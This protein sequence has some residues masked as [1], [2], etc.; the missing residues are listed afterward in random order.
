MGYHCRT[1]MT[2]TFY[3]V[4]G[5]AEDATIDEIEAAYRER[6]KHVHPDVNDDAD[7]GESTRTLIEARDVL[8]DEAERARYDRLGHEAYVG[9]DDESESDVAAAARR[10]GY[11]SGGGDGDEK[12]TQSNPRD[13]RQ[14]ARER[15]ERER[16]ASERVRQD[17]E[18]RATGRRTDTGSAT[19]GDDGG[20]DTGGPNGGTDAGSTGG[21]R[22]GTGPAWN[23]GG[24]T[25]SNTTPQGTTADDW[26]P[27]GR[28]LTLLGITFSLYPVLLFSALVPAF[29]LF[30]NLVLGAC[31]VLVVGYLQ[32]MPRI[33]LLVFGPWSIVTPFVLVGLNLSFV[34]L[35]G[36]AALLAT[37]LPFGFTILTISVLRL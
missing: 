26:V 23:S 3:D 9:N 32:S 18:S 37:W 25:A 4:L 15:R 35:V 24:H 11:G 28:E 27:T 17:R 30:V 14:R 20:P 33:A 8:V 13:A 12:S 10:A 1:R 19:R 29:P 16:R 6:L 2:E 21:F 7:A 36:I 31:L 34:S 5:I 22:G